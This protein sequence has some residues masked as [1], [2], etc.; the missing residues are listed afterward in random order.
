MA[1]QEI[2]PHDTRAPLVKHQCRDMACHKMYIHAQIRRR[3]ARHGIPPTRAPGEMDT[4]AQMR[5][6]MPE[7]RGRTHTQ[8]PIAFSVSRTWHATGEA[9]GRTKYEHLM[10]RFRQQHQ[11]W[12]ATRRSGSPGHGMPSFSRDGNIGHDD[13][14]RRFSRCFFQTSISER[15]KRIS[16]FE[17]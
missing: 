13:V 11:T 10:E 12:H 4:Q 9:E 3:T 8:R 15:S 14:F 17:R 1:C 2:G 6:G 7:Q 5:H 16:P